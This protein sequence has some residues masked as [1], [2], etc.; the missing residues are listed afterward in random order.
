MGVKDSKL[1]ETVSNAQSTN[2]NATQNVQNVQGATQ[3]VRGATQNVRDATQNVHQDTDGNT[4]IKF[5]GELSDLI[6]EHLRK[7]VK[8]KEF[9]TLKSTDFSMISGGILQH[10]GEKKICD[11][12]FHI[13]GKHEKC[14][15]LLGSICFDLFK[16]YG[17]E[18]LKLNFS[19]NSKSLRL[20]LSSFEEYKDLTVMISTRYY[21]G[22]DNVL[23]LNVNRELKSSAR[24]IFE[25]G[26]K[27]L[28]E[29]DL[30]PS[31]LELISPDDFI[32]NLTQI[33]LHVDAY[34]PLFDALLNPERLD[35]ENNY[36]NE[37]T[38]TQATSNE[39]LIAKARAMLA[40]KEYRVSCVNN[41]TGKYGISWIFN[42]EDFIPLLLEYNENGN[43]GQFF[44]EKK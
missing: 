31:S 1:D 15:V 38:I 5:R 37:N 33:S 18:T 7:G 26:K 13:P 8:D 3:N 10:D 39:E 16:G 21:D 14:T 40:Q 9:G 44:R 20:Y 11:L 22:L 30:S 42:Y 35:S 4:N 27:S 23:L 28:K 41:E 43:T 24:F 32:E 34:L 6:Y 36:P 2:G 29:I 19:G 12:Q 25:I 17:I